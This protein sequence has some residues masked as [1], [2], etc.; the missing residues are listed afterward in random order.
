MGECVFPE[1][2]GEHGRTWE[3]AQT[4]GE[5]CRVLQYCSC[6]SGLNEG[7]L[8]GKIK[9]CSYWLHHCT[10]T[11]NSWW[12]CCCLW[13]SLWKRQGARTW[14]H[15]SLPTVHSGA[16]T[17]A[18]AR[19]Y[20]RCS[21][22]IWFEFS[23]RWSNRWSKGCRKRRWDGRTRARGDIKIKRAIGFMG[24]FPR[25]VSMRPLCSLRPAG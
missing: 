13:R 6:H 18:V 2:T 21:E 7:K 12:L 9:T 5:H 16:V 20:L 14:F 15:R 11:A 8:A 4:T 25:W 22:F 3:N 19:E 1:S 10:I 17:A 24:S 23:P